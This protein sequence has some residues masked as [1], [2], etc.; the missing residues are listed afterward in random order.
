MEQFFAAEGLPHLM[1]FYQEPEQDEAGKGKVLGEKV[2][3][4]V[5]KANITVEETILNTPPKNE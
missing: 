5:T 3:F 2:E 1:F 4:W